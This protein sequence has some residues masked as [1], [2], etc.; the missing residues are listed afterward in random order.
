M[1]RQFALIFAF[2]ILPIFITSNVLATDAYTYLQSNLRLFS[3]LTPFQDQWISLENDVFGIESVDQKVDWK[4]LNDRGISL[5]EH[6]ILLVKHFAEDTQKIKADLSPEILKV[7]Q[8]FIDQ[9]FIYID[10]IDHSTLKLAEIT[11]H[12]YKMTI[13]P[14][15]WTAEKYLKELEKYE[16]LRDEYKRQ[17][18][19]LNT[20]FN[21]L[22][23]LNLNVK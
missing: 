8:P 7:I 17:G 3:E 20:E 16:L 12:L 21:K 5:V 1:K 18:I 10:I 2:G 4:R 15:S 19:K 11:N 14:Y 13:D 22:K 23:T 6:Q 9:L